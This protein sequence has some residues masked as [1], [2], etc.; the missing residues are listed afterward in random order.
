VIDQVRGRLRHAAAVARRA[1]ATSLARE[2]HEK[3]VTTRRAPCSG[4]TKTEDDAAEILP[5]LFLNVFRHGPLPDGPLGKPGLEVPGDESVERRLLGPA[6]LIPLRRPVRRESPRRRGRCMLADRDHGR[7]RF[8]V[9]LHLGKRSR[10][11]SQEQMSKKHQKRRHCR[12]P[13]RTRL[14]EG[15]HGG[16][17]RWRDCDLGLRQPPDRVCPCLPLHLYA[18]RPPSDSFASACRLR[19]SSTSPR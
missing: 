2:R 10:G 1:D 15:R 6:A 16:R 11:P 3:P 9:G 14:T 7:A 8:P 5:K 13:D 17:D 18:V 12:P 19:C 4:K